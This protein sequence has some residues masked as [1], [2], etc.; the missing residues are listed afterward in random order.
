M[1][2]AVNMAMARDEECNSLN[3]KE[4]FEQLKRYSD[5]IQQHKLV[6]ETKLDK[7]LGSRKARLISWLIKMLSKSA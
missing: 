4:S 6:L 7:F 5:L 3:P 1:T 2:A